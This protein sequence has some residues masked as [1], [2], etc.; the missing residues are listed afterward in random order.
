MAGL[1]TSE[2]TLSYA[3][4]PYAAAPATGRLDLHREEQEALA[5]AAL[6]L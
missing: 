3:G 6:T 4:R 2:Q 1:L 5:T